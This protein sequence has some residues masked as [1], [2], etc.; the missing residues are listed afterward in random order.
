MEGRSRRT[1]RTYRV[2]RE[3]ERSRIE[4]AVL[5]EAYRKI[6]PDDRLKLVE[7]SGMPGEAP[8]RSDVVAAV[9]KDINLVYQVSAIGGQS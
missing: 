1:R 7:R 8:E 5:A 6:L 2:H 4:N 9:S 3:F